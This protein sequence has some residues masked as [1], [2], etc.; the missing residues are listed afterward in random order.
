MDESKNFRVDQIKRKVHVRKL[1][2]MIAD[3]ALNKGKELL[4]EQK[5]VEMEERD[6]L[7]RLQ[8]ERGKLEKEKMKKEREEKRKQQLQ[9]LHNRRNTYIVPTMSSM[10][11]D[12]N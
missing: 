3:I 11:K 9:K 8:R 12:Q 6:R 1:K 5:V 2:K 10:M 7:E 4:Q